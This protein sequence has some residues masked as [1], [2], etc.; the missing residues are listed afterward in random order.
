MYAPAQIAYDEFF[1]A[2][3]EEPGPDRRASVRAAFRRGQRSYPT[4]LVAWEEFEDYYKFICGCFESD[5]QFIMTL[6]RAWDLDKSPSDSIETRHHQA[7]P[8]AGIPP[9]GRSGLHHWQENTLPK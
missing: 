4:N 2:L 5:A 6:T 1:Q 8:A 9:K 3:K 7:A